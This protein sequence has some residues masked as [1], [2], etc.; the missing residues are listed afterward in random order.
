MSDRTL[1]QQRLD[2]SQRKGGAPLAGIGQP[3]SLPRGQRAS[4]TLAR[5]PTRSESPE[6]H[7]TQEREGSARG[8]Q[9]RSSA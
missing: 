5:R 6:I 9:P 2:Y 7:V 1:T 4:T 8:G 3:G